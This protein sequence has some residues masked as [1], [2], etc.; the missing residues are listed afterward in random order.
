LIKNQKETTPISLP[1]GS[2]YEP[3]R[4]AVEAA[5][6]NDKMANAGMPAQQWA[7]QVVQDLLKKKPPMTIW[8][9]AQASLGRIGT[10]LPHGMLD[11]TMRK[12]TGLD[13]VEEKVRKGVATTI[14]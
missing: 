13:V 8:R 3:A 11:G 5:M 9:G 1:K 10:F 4:E 2:I 12:M 14:S 7:G 6:R